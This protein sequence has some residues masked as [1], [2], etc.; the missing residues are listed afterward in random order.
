MAANPEELAPAAAP[1]LAL[2]LLPCPLSKYSDEPEATA[3]AGGAAAA[4]PAAALLLLLL[5]EEVA[6]LQPLAPDVLGPDPAP[7]AAD[8]FCCSM[9]SIMLPDG[10]LGMAIRLAP[11]RRER[12]T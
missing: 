5:E 10:R 4:V 2:L 6:L 12:R 11:F 1:A 3:G 8:T 9:G 7:A